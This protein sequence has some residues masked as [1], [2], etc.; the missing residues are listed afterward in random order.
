[1]SGNVPP[2]AEQEEGQQQQQQ[3]QQV[4]EGSGVTGK[5]DPPPPVR[6]DSSCL[7]EDVRLWVLEISPSGLVDS[8]RMH[9]VRRE[10]NFSIPY[11]VA[12]VSR[13]C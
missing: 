1:M 9:T 5:E 6:R 12:G 11:G 3:Q 10:G 4:Q 8:P 7:T 2:D 13:C